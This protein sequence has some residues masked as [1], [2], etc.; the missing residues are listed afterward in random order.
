VKKVQA[1]LAA[2]AVIAAVVTACGGHGS[3]SEDAATAPASQDTTSAIAA[4]TLTIASMAF[5]QPLTVAPGTQIDIVNNDTVEHSVTSKTQGA[6]DVHV[7]GGKRKTLTAPAAP[8]Q[9]QF[10]CVYHPSMTGTL[11]VR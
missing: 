6:F 5:D 1:S 2:M 9:Y 4:P 7:D 11:T 3:S 10:F 8:G